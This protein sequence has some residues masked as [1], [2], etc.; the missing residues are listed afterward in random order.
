MLRETDIGTEDP[1]AG[2]TLRYASVDA[3]VDA[4]T[5]RQEMPQQ[6]ANGQL[7]VLGAPDRVGAFGM[8]TVR[9]S[10]VDEVAAQPGRM[11]WLSRK[12]FVGSYSPLSALRRSNFT[13]PYASRTRSS[14]SSI[15]KFTY[16]LV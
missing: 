13:T 11:F 5:F 15:K 3:F 6:V 16:T 4:V 2:V 7:R 9:G 10:S 8:A 12:K 14:P 1:D